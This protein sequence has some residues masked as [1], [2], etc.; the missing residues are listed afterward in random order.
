VAQFFSLG[1]IRAMPT[2]E[3]PA[4]DIWRILFRCFT[5][6]SLTLSLAILWGQISRQSFRDILDGLPLQA[7][8]I[9]GVVLFVLSLISVWFR[10]FRSL[11]VEGLVVSIWTLFVCLIPTV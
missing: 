9:C 11:A 7:T 3:H 5:V 2:T 4:R 1:H 10:R 6:A 8:M